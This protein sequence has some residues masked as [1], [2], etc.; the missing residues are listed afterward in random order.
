MKHYKEVLVPEE[1]RSVRSHTTC[2]LCRE[3]M[4]MPNGYRQE[5]I[6][7][8]ARVGTCYPDGGDGTTTS[9]D[10]CFKCWESKLLPWMLTQGAVVTIEEWDY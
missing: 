4:A 1:V 6:D 10:V 7:V 2:D 3:T 9:F 8:R 5:D